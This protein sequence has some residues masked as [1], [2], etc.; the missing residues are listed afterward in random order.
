M[1]QTRL[2]EG[3]CV[4]VQFFEFEGARKM[5]LAFAIMV[6]LADWTVPVSCFFILYGMVVISMQRRKRVSQFESNRSVLKMYLL[7]PAGTSVISS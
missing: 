6:F 7:H 3:E 2:E 4:G 5:Y 1:L